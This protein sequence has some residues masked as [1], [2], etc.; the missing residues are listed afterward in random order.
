M[1]FSARRIDEIGAL[2]MLGM[3]LLVVSGVSYVLLAHQS[4]SIGAA[5]LTGVTLLFMVVPLVP[6]WLRESS[7]VTLLVYGL[8]SASTWSA[9]SSTR[10]RWR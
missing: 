6:W 4:G 10:R 9:A 2:H 1:W 7:I 8:F 3:T 5:L